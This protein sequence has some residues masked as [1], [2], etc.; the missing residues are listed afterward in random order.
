MI[1]MTEYIELQEFPWEDGWEIK[2]PLPSVEKMGL[3]QATIEEK[4]TRA[5]LW[6]I[7][8]IKIALDLETSGK[9]PECLRELNKELQ[10]LHN[11]IVL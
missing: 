7:D 3:R 11:K 6:A 1:E 9:K 5:I 10:R 2:F 8:T 4:T